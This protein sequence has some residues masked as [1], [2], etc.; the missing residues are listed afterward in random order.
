M[1][2]SF[3]ALAL[4]LAVAVATSSTAFASSLV[5]VS[6]VNLFASCTAG[7]GPFGAVN[8]P[9]AEVEPF[10]AAD[11]RDRDHLV[12][13]W[14][15]DRWS[16][17]GAH[18]LIAA[19][20]SNGG[21]TW[22]LS[23]LPFSKCAPGGVDYE[24]SSDPG[25][26]V[27]PDGIVYAI[28]LPFDGDFIRNGVSVARSVD[29]GRTWRDTTLISKLVARPD[30]LNPADDKELV[31]A[32]PTR[33]RTAYAVW[34]R[35]ED[36][37]GTTRTHNPER[38]GPEPAQPTPIGFTGPTFFSRT[39]DGGKTWET[40]RVIV[41]TGLNEQTIGNY[42]VVDHRTGRLYDFFDFI[43]ADGSTSIQFVTSND[44]GVTWSGRQFVS[45]Q[46][47]TAAGVIDPNTNEPVRTG[48][49]VPIPAID[50]NNGDLFVV[51]QDTR[52]SGGA[53]EEVAI[54]ASFDGGKHWT[55]PKRVNTPTGSQAFTPT[56]AVTEDGTVGVTYYDFRT[57][58]PG[59][60][61]TL[62][63]G[64]FLKKTEPGDARELEF[65]DDIVISQPF[66]MR[67]APVARGFFVG[68]YEGLTSVGDRFVPFFVKANSG[69]LANR[70][71]VFAAP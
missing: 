6:R 63:T 30:T 66:D 19:T 43:A 22:Q 47:L 36:V 5:L 31:F 56:V 24:R 7:A 23:A 45:D 27:G 33:R 62:P 15:Q 2:R 1:R 14:Q 50:P 10:V 68:D 69:N 11:P 51:F 25:I 52:F 71:D 39:T 9:N 54:T 8:F 4:G 60:V 67:T 42:V 70:T 29:G 18:G 65:G 32:D 17:G 53:F 55:K 59:N 16:D 40:A 28:G 34:D 26:S 49:I 12:A 37:F 20:S 35:I 13:D 48:D 44:R 46:G 38:S 58:K 61:T 41:P 57:L 64:Y 3:T 21:R